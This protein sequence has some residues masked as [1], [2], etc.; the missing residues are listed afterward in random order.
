MPM[1]CA[2]SHVPPKK[3]KHGDNALIFSREERLKTHLTHLLQSVHQSSQS[4]QSLQVLT[5]A[6]GHLDEA[7]EGVVH[8]VVEPGGR[9][10]G[11]PEERRLQR[12]QCERKNTDFFFLISTTWGG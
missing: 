4:S 12:K 10:E 8:T 11:G 6:V 3:N 1:D 7:M 5:S 9:G 2:T